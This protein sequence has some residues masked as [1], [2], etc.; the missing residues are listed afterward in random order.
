VEHVFQRPRQA[1]ELPDNDNITLAQLV[2]HAVQLGPVPAPSGGGLLED[3]AAAGRAERLGLQCIT[4]LVSF[5]DSGVAKKQAVTA[6]HKR[7]FA[8]RIV[9]HRVST[10]ICFR[11][12]VSELL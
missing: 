9:R 6:F 2:E 4:L 1:V 12:P 5:G 11:N 7:P 8:H 3:A 10:G